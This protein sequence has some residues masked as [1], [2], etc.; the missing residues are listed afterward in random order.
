MSGERARKIT[1]MY[2]LLAITWK[3]RKGQPREYIAICTGG[4]IPMLLLHQELAKQNKVPESWI[5]FHLYATAKE[6]RRAAPKLYQEFLIYKK[7]KAQT[8]DRDE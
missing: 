5:D 8:G 1:K 3:R 6:V 2:W 7:A 4:P